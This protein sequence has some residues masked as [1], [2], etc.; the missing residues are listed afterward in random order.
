MKDKVSQI[1]KRLKSVTMVSL[2][3]VL[4][5]IGYIPYIKAAGCGDK[6]LEPETEQCDLGTTQYLFDLVSSGAAG[7]NSPID[8]T[9][10]PDGYL[11]VTA[12]GGGLDRVYRFDAANGVYFDVFVDDVGGPG[13]D[14]P[15]GISFGPDGNVYVSAFSSNSVIAYQHPLGDPLGDPLGMDSVDFIAPGLDGLNSP[16]AHVFAPDD[17]L[18]VASFGTDQILHYDANG[19]SLGM[20]PFVDTDLDG[21][22]DAPSEIIF[23]P[24][25][26]LYVS[27]AASDEVLVYDPDTGDLLEVFVGPDAEGRPDYPSGM[28]F[29]PDGDLYLI[30]RLSSEIL[31]Y[32]G[33][34]GELKDIPVS[35]VSAR[36]LAINDGRLCF[37]DSVSSRVLCYILEGLNSNEPNATCRSDCTEQRCGDGIIDTDFGE[38]CDNGNL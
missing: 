1:L 14:N 38:V 32:D 30:S 27:S 8:L 12:N 37:T 25:G 33:M 15:N 4:I 34:T 9:F 35:G 6:I 22:P 17:S 29:G 26:N 20:G 7:I 28:A 11:Y 19:D 13:L 24:D 36:Y 16:T 31:R 10:G 5:G 2:M 3:G 23:G 21:R 18:Y